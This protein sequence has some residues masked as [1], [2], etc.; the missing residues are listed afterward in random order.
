MKIIVLDAETL[1]FPEA[2]WSALAA[3]GELVLHDST[4]ADEDAVVERCSGATVVLTNKV[5]ISRSALERLPDLRMIGA[6][7][8]GFNTIDTEAAKERGIIVCNVPDYSTGSV[9]QHTLALILELT[10]HVSAHTASVYNGD[11]VKS[12]QFS[13][14]KSELI[15]LSECVVGIVGFGEIGR[16]VG[17]LV[18]LLGATVIAHTRTPRNPPDWPGFEFVERDEL[19]ERSDIV[20]LHC[21]L[22][23]ENTGFVNA[24]LLSR[25]KRSA[26]LINTARGAL[27]NEA[28]LARAL[29]SGSIGGAGIDVVSHEPMRIDNPLLDARHCVITPHIAWAGPKSR[30]SL[31]E[32]TVQNVRSFKAGSPRNQVA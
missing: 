21:P 12:R 28:D 8:T 22:T 26:L 29:N 9:A 23:P 32:I 15:E 14:W 2:E 31:L 17:A 16:R 7:A 11:W 1:R 3:E 24:A 6:L 4:A 25:M 19:F 18:Q 13:Y 5:P 27:V 20:S 30:K 10:N